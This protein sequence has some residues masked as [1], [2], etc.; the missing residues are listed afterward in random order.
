[1]GW[2]QRIAV[3]T[4]AVALVLTGCGE[5]DETGEDA[6]SA[7]AAGDGS[8]ADEKAVTDVAN[9]FF[10]EGLTQG[11]LAACDLLTP[12]AEKA[13]S[14]VYETKNGT[15]AEGIAFLANQGNPSKTLYDIQSVAVTGDTA[16]VTFAFSEAE[17]VREGDAWLVSDTGLSG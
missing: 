8:A 13:F 5:G 10:T 2:K 15:C 7:P 3:L 16:T 14:Q 11:D 9:A 12:E 4:L 1:V 6:G 17:L